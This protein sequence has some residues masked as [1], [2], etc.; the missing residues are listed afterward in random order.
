MINMVVK[1]SSKELEELRKEN[2]E[3]KK[4][5][6]VDSHDQSHLSKYKIIKLLEKDI[7]SSENMAIQSYLN[8]KLQISASIHTPM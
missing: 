3:L 2:S 8:C 1:V 5:N 6:Y 4:K 7:Q